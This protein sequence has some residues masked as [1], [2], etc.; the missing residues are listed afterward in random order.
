MM[1]LLTFQIVSQFHKIW[2][3]YCTFRDRTSTVQFNFLQA[4]P[5][6]WEVSY[7]NLV[8]D[9]DGRD[10]GLARFSSDP[11]KIQENISKY[12]RNARQDHPLIQFDAKQVLK[13]MQCR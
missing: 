8:R 9:A 7:S 5:C 4:V 3:E 10:W 2:Y 11:E 1:C 12:A 6:T 13:L